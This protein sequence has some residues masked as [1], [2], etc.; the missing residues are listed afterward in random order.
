M[1]KPDIW[2]DCEQIYSLKALKC[3]SCGRIHYPHTQIC[4]GCG[5]ANDF[6][7]VKIEPEGKIYSFTVNYA[8]PSEFTVPS[9]LAIV[10]TSNR[11]RVHGLM[12]DVNPEDVKIGQRVKLV[13][14]KIREIDDV[15]VYGFKI[16]PFLDR[17]E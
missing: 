13:F 3:N 4:L 6:T 16:K 11:V 8:V 17:G 2:R 12:I 5:K 14:R 9:I 1:Y 15:P 10:E 7:S